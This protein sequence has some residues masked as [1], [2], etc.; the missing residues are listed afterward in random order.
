[1]DSDHLAYFFCLI[2][3]EMIIIV[4]AEL[5]SGIRNLRSYFN[6]R[7]TKSGISAEVSAFA[8]VSAKKSL[9]VQRAL[10][11]VPFSTDSQD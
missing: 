7:V 11:L 6:T 2:I 10:Q 5:G 8:E 3:S 9:H 4:I 1:M